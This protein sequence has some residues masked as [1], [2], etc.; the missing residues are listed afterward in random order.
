[1]KRNMV[2]IVILNYN[3]WGESVEC[4]ESIVNH[5]K[6]EYKIYLIDNHSTVSMTQAQQ[7][8]LKELGAVVFLNTENRGYAAGNNIGLQ[9][10]AE[11]GC[12]QMMVCNPDVRFVDNSIGVLCQFAAT[13]NDAAIVGPLLYDED[14]K[15]HPT[16]MRIKLTASG[17]IKNM[18]LSTPFRPLFRK[19]ENAFY[20]SEPFSKPEKVFSVAGSCFLITQKG[21]AQVFPFDENT[22]LYEEEYI[23]GCRI[24][25]KGLSAYVVPETKVIHSYAASTG[26]INAFSYKCLVESEQYY[27][28][29]YLHTNKTM[30]WLI[31]L[32]RRIN[33]NI[34]YKRVKR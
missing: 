4:I 2:G 21:Y 25:G 18:F 8:K 24:E 14:G 17:K 6:A 28:G 1:M 23:L 15:Y 16:S 9:M 27:L 33:W 26:G 11:D 31:R 20:S 12:D 30:L 19:F 22:F 7:I 10:A 13:Q 34:R 29:H 32:L 3:S 5:T